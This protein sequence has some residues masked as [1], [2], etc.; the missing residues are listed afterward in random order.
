MMWPL[1]WFKKQEKGPGLKVKFAVGDKIPWK[2]IWF[3]VS[4]VEHAQI[5]LTPIS[6][7]AQFSKRRMMAVSRQAR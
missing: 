6:T 5:E 2:G 7:T 1:S 3:E 4:K